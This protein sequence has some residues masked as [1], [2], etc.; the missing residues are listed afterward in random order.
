MQKECQVILLPTIKE[1]HLLI[2]ANDKMA[3]RERPKGRLESHDSP[4]ASSEDFTAQHLCICS[5]EEIKEGDWYIAK[6]NTLCQ[7]YAS[8]SVE[9]DRRIVATTDRSIKNYTTKVSATYIGG[10]TAE[11]KTISYFLP[12][13]SQSFI[14]KYISEYNKGNII[15]SVMVEYDYINGWSQKLVEYQNHPEN[16]HIQLKLN[17]N[18]IIIKT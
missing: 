4:W 6:D 18:E 11:V 16:L 2:V 13:I 12:T 1:S 10:E 3:F 5:N 17:G 14:D 7:R 9:G 8:E 15:I